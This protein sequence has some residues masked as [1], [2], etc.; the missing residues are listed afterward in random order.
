MVSRKDFEVSVLQSRR[1]VLDKVFVVSKV[2]YRECKEEEEEEEEV[3]ECLRRRLFI[4]RG[5][6]GRLGHVTKRKV[7]LE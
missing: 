7:A 5:S 3:S 2:S 6:K 4:D 1:D